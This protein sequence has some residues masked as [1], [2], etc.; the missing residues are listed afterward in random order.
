[1]A[2]T[3]KSRRNEMETTVFRRSSGFY[4]RKSQPGTAKV[5]GVMAL[6]TTVDTK[7]CMILLYYIIP[8]FPAHRYLGSCRI[9]SFNAS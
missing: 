3:E 4:V 1:M 8:Q 2:Q 7:S 9:C 6:F 5:Y